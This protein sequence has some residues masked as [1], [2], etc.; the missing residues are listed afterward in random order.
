MTFGRTAATAIVALS[1]TVGACSHAFRQPEVTV[2]GARLGGIGLRG[3]LVYFDVAVKNPNHYTLRANHFAY[4]LR[5]QDPGD[6]NNWLP[7]TT[8]SYDQ[9][10]KIG[11]G[12]TQTLEVPISFDFAK[13]ASAVQSVMD[14]GILNYKVTGQVHVTEPI[15]RNVPFAHQG[16]VTMSGGR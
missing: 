16:V 15:T 1:M 7:F 2:T 8:G 9:D 14:R 10:V 5:V 6:A 3:G 12:D 4:D 13:S 11:G